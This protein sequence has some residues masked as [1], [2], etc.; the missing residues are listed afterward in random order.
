MINLINFFGSEFFQMYNPL[1]KLKNYKNY[2][3]TK[4]SLFNTVKKYII[5]Y[6]LI[7]KFYYN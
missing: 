5:I 4:K 1:F 3:I 6:Y 7:I 2:L